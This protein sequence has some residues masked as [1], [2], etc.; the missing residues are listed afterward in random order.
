MIV[1]KSRFINMFSPDI[2]QEINGHLYV[3]NK[4]HVYRLTYSKHEIH[5]KTGD[6]LKFDL[7]KRIEP[8]KAEYQKHNAIKWLCQILQIPNTVDRDVIISDEVIKANLSEFIQHHAIFN[9]AFNLNIKPPNSFKGVLGMIRSI[10]KAW[11]G[12]SLIVNSK[13][14]TVI[15]GIRE[16]RFTYKLVA[17]TDS[18]DL[19][20]EHMIKKQPPNIVERLIPGE[21]DLLTV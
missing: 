20:L 21:L 16:E 3:E 14:N 10:I 11:S 8:G 13:M 4:N 5:H 1:A 9:T 17:P 12:S 7:N 6:V 15:N 19:L 2:H 18:F